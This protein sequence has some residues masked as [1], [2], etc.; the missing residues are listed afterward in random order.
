MTAQGPSGTP[1]ISP[2]PVLSVA[3]SSVAAEPAASRGPALSDHD[4]ASDFEHLQ[5]LCSKDQQ[6]LCRDRAAAA[7]RQEGKLI[8]EIQLTINAHL[9]AIEHCKVASETDPEWFTL[10]VQDCHSRKVRLLRSI[11]AKLQSDTAPLPENASVGD[12]FRGR[13]YAGYA[14]SA[15]VTERFTSRLQESESVQKAATGMQS[16]LGALSSRLRTVSSSD[17]LGAA[18]ARM[19]SFSSGPAASGHAADQ[20]TDSSPS[21]NQT[22]DNVVATAAAGEPLRSDETAAPAATVEAEPVTSA[23]AAGMAPAAGEAP[24]SSPEAQTMQVN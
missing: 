5:W 4:T 6:V 3:S 12:A 11:L 17:A 19:P 18:V 14:Q 13:L 22:P 23:A 20:T 2:Q 9:R 24:S 21:A 15:Q 10:D 1:S 16:A 7:V 8:A